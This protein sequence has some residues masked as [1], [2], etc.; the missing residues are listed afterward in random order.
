MAADP[1]PLPTLD[2]LRGPPVLVDFSFSPSVVEGESSLGGGIWGP[3]PPVAD[4]RVEGESGVVPFGLVVEGGEVG[5]SDSEDLSADAIA[6]MLSGTS[7]LDLFAWG[8]RPGA[9]GF[10]GLATTGKRP[11]SRRR[12]VLASRR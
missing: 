7:R 4:I 9:V 3:G 5:V 8:C 2:R 10:V 6:S 1:A 12:S 11:L